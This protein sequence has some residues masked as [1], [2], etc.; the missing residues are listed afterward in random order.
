MKSGIPERDG[1][2]AF[3]SPSYRTPDPVTRE[4]VRLAERLLG[5]RTVG[6]VLKHLVGTAASVVPEADLVS[7]TLRTPSGN[8]VTPVHT[9]ELAVRL[10]ELQ[11][12]FDEGPCVDATRVPGEGLV[13][14]ADSATCAAWPRWGPA[15]A[16][17]G[18]RS[19]LAAGL[20]P[21]GTPPW[22]GALNLYSFR[23]NGL[24]AV[25]RDI[26]MLLAAHAATALQTTDAATAAELKAAQLREALHSRDVIGQAK[27]ILMERRGVDADEAFK[28][29]REASQHLNMKLT[30]VAGM[31][32]EHREEI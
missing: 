24:D 5:A 21:L 26:A 16:E 30:E 25:D 11:Y 12:R 19:V 2:R 4:F 8:F 20:F 1:H 32:A 29:L 22:Y 14:Q 10:D 17:L 7:V 18:V 31:L 27:G 28:I 13:Y 9:D 23:A 3:G 15:A 6:D